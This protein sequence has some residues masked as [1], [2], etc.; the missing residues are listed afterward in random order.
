MLTG[1]R[2]PFLLL[3]ITG[4]T[5]SSSVVHAQDAASDQAKLLLKQG[6]AEYKALNF[7][8]AQATLLQLS[9]LLKSNDSALT[10]S[11]K[12][13][14]EDLFTKIRIAIPKQAAAKEA[15]RSAEKA[16]T[17]GRL[18]DAISGFARAATSEHLD[19]ATRRDA[20]AQLALAQRRKEAKAAAT[21]TPPPA[22]APTPTPKPAP[23]PTPKPAPTPTPAPA[24]KPPVAPAPA[25]KAVPVVTPVPAVAP[26]PAPAPKPVPVIA[27]TPTP[28]PTPA[29]T[30]AP[31]PVPVATP[32][33]TPVPVATPAPTPAPAAASSALQDLQERRAKA[34][35]LMTMGK[36]ALDQGQADVATKYFQRA[37]DLDPDLVEA[38]QMLQHTSKLV[39]LKQPSQAAILIRLER[40]NLIAWQAAQVEINKALDESIKVLSAAKK[41]SDYDNAEQAANRAMDTLQ[42][43]KSFA[44]ATTYRNEKARIENQLQ[45]I[46]VKRDGFNKEKA[47]A[48]AAEIE[49]IQAQR[50]LEEQRKLL[51]KVATL[52]EQARALRDQKKYDKSL[53][54]VRQILLIDPKNS[55]AEQQQEVLLEFDLI[56]KANDTF[57]TNRVEEAKSFWDNQRAEIPWYELVRYPKNW[58]QLS[59]DRKEFV[60]SAA[61]ESPAD[62]ALREKLMRE[63]ERLSFAEIDFKDVIQFLREYSDANIHVNRRALQAAGIEQNTKVTVDVRRITV[64][65]ALDLI[66]RDVSGAAAGA[67]AEL[68]YVV[69]GGV[70]IISTKADLAREPIRR[71]YDIRDLLVP[72][73]DF[74]G[75]RIELSE[76]AQESQNIGTS[77]S[78]SSGGI[79][80]DD[81]DLDQYE[82][83]EK[84]KEE[85][86]EDFIDL[87][88]NA[89]DRDSWGDPEGGGVG[90]GFIQVINGQLVV[91]QTAENHQALAELIEKLREAKTIQIMVEARF[92]VVDSGFLNNVGVDLD[93]YFNVGSDMQR[94]DGGA[95]TDPFTGSQVP[96]YT[97]ADGATVSSFP[98]QG[99]SPWYTGRSDQRWSPVGAKNNSSGFVS[100]GL[101]TQ[102]ASNIGLAVSNSGPA[103]SVGGTFLDDIQV[104]FLIQA[105]QAHASTRQLTAPRITLSNSQRAYI[106]VARQQ[107]YIREYVPVVSGNAVAYTP[108]I[109]YIPTGMV[110][111]VAATASSDRRYVMMT[112]RPQI[113]TQ[114]GQP[115]TLSI[116]GGGPNGVLPVQLPTVSIQQVETTVSVPDEGTLLLGGQRITGEIERE[117]GAPVLNKIPI[118]NRAFSNRGTVRDERVLLILVKPKII[119]NEQAERNEKLYVEEPR[120]P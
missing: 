43:N 92:I 77:G 13:Q 100:S 73:P 60:A 82:E 99:T 2:S 36:R 97:N 108:V 16:L 40:R 20:R 23:A 57:R 62:A 75:P 120:L 4:L 72:V 53:E 9:T 19:E 118:I 51:R 26:A 59:E 49:R 29:P 33:P 63:I 76:A 103:L 1:R 86:T 80:E 64:K 8:K 25:P 11:E 69:D 107:A 90:V 32:K 30:P 83:E 48:E 94:A 85:L 39:A 105:T 95:V 70:L 56:M 87:V 78:G 74:R 88:K 54:V 37:L 50:R 35:Q 24:P 93:F 79:F 89:I 6:T 104:D 58:K 52:T 42:A 7:T 119:I 98:L 84:T 113:A 55:W 96:T 12:T 47:A 114:E 91:T 110:L 41:A 15:Y 45:Q 68:R 27:A 102:V 44:P 67:D 5:L 116:G 71:V 17:A 46:A 109:S 112:I 38:R 101:E 22:P 66:L 31:T 34:R 61:G 14:L 3:L 81:S 28:T 111:D 10:A 65:R 106:T 117:M 18:D 21:A 115:T